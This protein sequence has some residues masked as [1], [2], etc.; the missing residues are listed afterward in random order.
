MTTAAYV[1]L[2]LL[3]AGL[4]LPWLITAILFGEEAA[5][6]APLPAVALVLVVVAWLKSPRPGSDGPPASLDEKE[7]R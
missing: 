2:V 7:R 3:L 5:D 6:Y 1:L 4:T